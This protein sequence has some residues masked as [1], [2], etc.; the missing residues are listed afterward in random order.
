[1]FQGIYDYDL[2]FMKHDFSFA[3]GSNLM[4]NVRQTA[5]L[6]GSKGG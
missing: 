5:V 3:F 4:A 6:E 1:M 2:V